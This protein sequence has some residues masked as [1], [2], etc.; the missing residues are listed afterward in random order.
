MSIGFVGLGRMGSGICQNLVA[1]SGERVVAF[2]LSPAALEAAVGAGAVAASSVA[3]LAAESEVIFTSLPMPADVEAVALG[4]EGIRDGARE[5]TVYFDL[6]TSAPAVTQRIAAE[7]AAG[8]VTM[9]DAP[10]SGGPAGAEAGTLGVMVGGDEEVFERQLPLLRTFSANPIHVGELGSGLVTKLV[11][12]LIALCGVATA[13]E[14]LMLGTAAGVDPKKL[15]AA[16]RASSGDSIAYRSLA[17]RA[18][19][20]DYSASFTLN[21]SYKD[22]HLALELADELRVPTQMGNSMHNLQRMASGLGLGQSD[23]TSVVKVYE[24]LA[25]RTVGE[26]PAA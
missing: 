6:T 5:G 12:N 25:G 2:D 19:S 24:T 4:A 13:A 8:G 22:I 10:V 20:G 1:K 9:L 7:L 17:D 26:G 16:I 14:A 23:P 18:L 11:N 3:A 15:D 21:L